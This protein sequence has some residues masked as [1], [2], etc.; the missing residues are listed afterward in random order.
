[1]NFVSVEKRVLNPYAISPED[2]KILHNDVFPFWIKRN[3]REVTRSKHG[4]PLCQRIDERFIAYFVWKSVGI[5]HTIPDFSTV[6]KKGTGGI[7]EDIQARLDKG[8]LKM[9]R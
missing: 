2:V 3:F 1:V 7:I 5:S 4:N 6:L 9:I 8:A